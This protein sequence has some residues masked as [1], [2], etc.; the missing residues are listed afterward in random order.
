MMKLYGIFTD[1]KW[2]ICRNRKQSL[3]LARTIK[4]EVRQLTDVSEVSIYDRPTF[5]ILSEQIADFRETRTSIFDAAFSAAELQQQ[6]GLTSCLAGRGAV[7][8]GVDCS[9]T[10]QSEL[11][12]RR[13]ALAKRM[14]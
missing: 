12:Q 11:C 13:I 2:A 3:Q 4:A 10:D 7:C 6:T 1:Q 8:P 9:R 14:P 5:H